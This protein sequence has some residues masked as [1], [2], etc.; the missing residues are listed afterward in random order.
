MLPNDDYYW[1]R[2]RLRAAELDS[3]CCSGVPDFYPDACKEHDIH[4]RTH[5][6]IDGYA[7]TRAE[8]DAWFRRRIQQRSHFGRL[9]PMSW[10]RYFGVRLFGRRAWTGR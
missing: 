2:V 4:Y 1:A 5:Q 7:I 3:N 8:A 9:S 6:T 10:W